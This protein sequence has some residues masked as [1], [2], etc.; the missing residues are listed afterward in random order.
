MKKIVAL[1]LIA[2]GLTLVNIQEI[3]TYKP[4]CTKVLTLEDTVNSFKLDTTIK[5]IC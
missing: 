4:E 2:L 1:T 3:N 5:E